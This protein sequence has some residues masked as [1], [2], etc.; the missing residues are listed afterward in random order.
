MFGAAAA[1]ALVGAGAMLLVGDVGPGRDRAEIEGIVQAYILDNPDILPKAM[2]RLQSRETAKAV[3]AQRAAIETPFG[4]AWAGAE[5]GDVVLVE[6][7]DYACGYC[8][9]SVEDIER[10]LGEDEKL[11]VVWRELPVLGPHSETAAMASLAAANQ[12][13]FKDFHNRLFGLGRPSEAAVAEAA[14]TAGVT[15]VEDQA[16]LRTEIE[17]NYRLAQSIGATGTPTFVVGDE[18]LQGAVGYEALKAA[19]ARARAEA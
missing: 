17:K 10:L 1:G 9:K 8:R 5:D 11:K 7:Y 4:S 14:A 12:G 15:A 19:I 3:D 16:P 13:K 2:Q 18:V 6:F